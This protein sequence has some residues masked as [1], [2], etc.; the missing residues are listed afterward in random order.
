[1]SADVLGD[2][3]R[4]QMIENALIDVVSP[5]FI[6]SAVND[7]ICRRS[8]GGEIFLIAF[9]EDDSTTRGLG[10]DVLAAGA[11]VGDVFVFDTISDAGYWIS[12]IEFSRAIEA[13]LRDLFDSGRVGSDDYSR[14]MGLVAARPAL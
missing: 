11:N 3:G 13:R 6:E 9:V 8:R 12:R 5:P 4:L 14:L 1:M 7:L 2:D 10:T